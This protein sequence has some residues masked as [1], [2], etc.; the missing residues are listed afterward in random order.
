MARQLFVTWN[1]GGNLV[2]ALGIARMLGERGH[3]VAF[4]GQDTQQRRIEAADF[5]FA[6]Y[7]SVPPWAGTTPLSPAQAQGQIMR[8]IWLN[9]GMADDVVTL[10]ARQPVDLVVID[11]MLAGVLAGS[12]AFGVPTVVLVHSLYVSVLSARD[13]LITVGN[14][15]RV[16]AGLPPLDTDAVR[17]E[18][19]DLVLVTTL[20]ELDGVPADPAPNVRYVGPVFER[21]PLPTPWELPWDREGLRPLVLASF[22]TNPWQG[23]AVALQQVLD[24]LA[25]L[26]LRVLLLTGGAVAPSALTPP[27]NAAVSGFVP[28][29]AVLP[30]AALA[31]THAGHGTVMNALAHGVPLVCRPSL[32][33]DQPIIAAR[34]QALR[35]GKTVAP[36]AGADTIRSAVMQ[37]LGTPTYRIAAQRLAALIARENGAAKGAAELEACMS[38]R[39]KPTPQLNRRVPVCGS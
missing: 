8:N 35:A 3:V 10:L 25:D 4:L 26:P 32:A 21:Q 34:V 39:H 36:D 16:E 29:A 20:R 31:I 19:K 9:T 7:A 38:S 5:G 15:L 28:H 27:A 17:W 23:S 1:G 33:A 22:S 14:R 18:N 24:A 11:C 37:V 13:T 30:Y 6:A 2:P 12:Q